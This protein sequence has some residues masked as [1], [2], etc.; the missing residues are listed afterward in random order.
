VNVSGTIAMITALLYSEMTG[1]AALESV[2]LGLLL[3][4]YT[5]S[6]RV[7]FKS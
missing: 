6:G 7:V 4:E 5:A 2:L 1:T 3:T